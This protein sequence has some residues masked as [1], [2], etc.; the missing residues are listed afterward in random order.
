[1][2]AKNERFSCSAAFNLNVIKYVKERGKR[3]ERH[4]HFH[5]VFR[6]SVRLFLVRLATDLNIP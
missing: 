5:V 1:M 4:F 6:R 2:L 3:A